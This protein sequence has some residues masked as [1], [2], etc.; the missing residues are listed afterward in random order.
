M[1]AEKAIGTA[2]SVIYTRPTYMEAEFIWRRFNLLKQC[3]NSLIGT[4]YSE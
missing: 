4:F 2:S 3:G 1:S